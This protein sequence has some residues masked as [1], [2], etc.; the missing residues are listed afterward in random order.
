MKKEHTYHT[1]ISKKTES[2][3]ISKPVN[4]HEE[5]VLKHVCVEYLDSYVLSIDTEITGEWQT[6]CCR[7]YLRK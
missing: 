6:T 7:N 4:N 5:T 2:T 1:S 3:T